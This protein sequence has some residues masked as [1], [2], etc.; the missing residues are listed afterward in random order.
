MRALSAEKTVKEDPVRLPHW[1]RGRSDCIKMPRLHRRS[2]DNPGCSSSTTIVRKFSRKAP[3]RGGRRIRTSAFHERSTIGINSDERFYP[4]SFD[5]L[6]SWK[7]SDSFGSSSFRQ[8]QRDFLSKIFERSLL[9]QTLLIIQ[10]IV[11]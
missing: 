2:I 9:Q 6:S 8:G 5:P 11:I 7:S 1:R 3:Y 4:I 10:L